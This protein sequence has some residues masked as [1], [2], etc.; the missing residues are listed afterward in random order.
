MFVKFFEMLEIS[1]VTDQAIEARWVLYWMGP[2][3]VVY[4]A[5]AV[6]L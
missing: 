2:S 1:F 4:K 3:G 6:L 5:S